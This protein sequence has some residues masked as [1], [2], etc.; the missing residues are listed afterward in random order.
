MS[1][2][3]SPKNHLLSPTRLELFSD[4]IF[5]IIITLTAIELHPPH[6]AD[7]SSLLSMLP[8]FLTYFV[9]FT[10]LG[11]YWMHH[12]RMFSTAHRI[13]NQILWAN[14]HMLFWLSLIPFSTSWF[15]QHQHDVW[16]TVFY[17]A[18]IFFSGIGSILLRW[19]IQ[20]SM[21]DTKAEAPA[22]EDSLRGALSF[23]LVTAAIVL[24][25]VNTTVSGYLYLAVSLS[26]ILPD[27][28]I[29]R[30]LLRADSQPTQP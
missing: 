28:G 13:T 20:A 17:G 10:I 9:S 23:I 22:A 18:V 15:G 24:A 21:V 11:S 7:L 19:A 27:L 30:F 12:H 25:F 14:L 3:K 26:W 4:A 6:D 1:D 2:T 29:G 5:A 16:P 8:Q